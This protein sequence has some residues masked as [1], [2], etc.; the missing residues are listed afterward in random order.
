MEVSIISPLT[1]GYK[2]G[3]LKEEKVVERLGGWGKLP[4]VENSRVISVRGREF[5]SL[6]GVVGS[7]S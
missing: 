4:I 1:L 5:K 2:Y 3:K 6:R 7:L